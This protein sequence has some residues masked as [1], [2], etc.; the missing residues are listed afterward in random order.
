MNCLLKNKK[1]L[2][3]FISFLFQI[4]LIQAQEQSFVA[5]DG[6][7]EFTMVSG[8]EE[9]LTL[10]FLVK[11]GFHIQA[12]QVKDENLIPTALYLSGPDQLLIGE[13][14]YPAAAEFHMRGAEESLLVFGDELKITIPIQINEPAKKT[15]FLNGKLHYQA[16]DDRKCFFPR[17]LPFVIKINVE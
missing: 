6:K 3:L 15:Y 7:L 12:N 9:H 17:D 13:P 1:Q 5:V 14:V 8:K 16:C 11:E 2:L 4:T 10:S